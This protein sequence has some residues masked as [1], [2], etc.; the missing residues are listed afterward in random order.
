M[1]KAQR[2]TVGLAGLLMGMTLAACSS[3]GAVATVNGQPISNA[4]FDARL[5]SSPMGRTV[6][7]QLVQE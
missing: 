1:S 2:I 6:L 7:Q 4:T 3:G 5:E